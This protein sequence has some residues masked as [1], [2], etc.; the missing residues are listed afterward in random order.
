V[1][2]ICFVGVVIGLCTSYCKSSLCSSF[3]TL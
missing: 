3:W 2:Q 1:L